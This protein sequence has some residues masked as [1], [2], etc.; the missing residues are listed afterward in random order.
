MK[1]KDFGMIVRTIGFICLFILLAFGSV[2]IPLFI[3]IL[4]TIGCLCIAISCKEKLF[5]IS[6]EHHKLVNYIIAFLGFIIIMKNYSAFSF[7]K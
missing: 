6:I 4:I 7:I 2:K 5:S 3:T 1:L